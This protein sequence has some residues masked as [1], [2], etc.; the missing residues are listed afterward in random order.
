[1]LKTL[2]SAALLVPLL[3][4]GCAD[5]ADEAE[6][7]DVDSPAA[8]ETSESADP[9]AE[10]E[11]A[12]QAYFDAMREGDTETICALEEDFWKQTKYDSAEAC[13]DDAANNQPQSVWAED[14]TVVEIVDNGTN[15]TAVIEPNVS[16]PAQA[17]IVLAEVAGRWQVTSLQ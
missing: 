15:V 2:A 9:T 5:D 17:Q 6:G 14:V 12:I 13:L 1:M 3:I 7:T 4:T 16:S 10:A 11:A 8:P